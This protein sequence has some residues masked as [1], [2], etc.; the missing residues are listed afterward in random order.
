MLLNRRRFVARMLSFAAPASI[1]LGRSAAGAEPGA[2][3]F[4]PVVTGRALVF[5]DDEGSHPYFRIEWWYLTGWLSDEMNRLS[6]FQITFF[7]S[8][9]QSTGGNP[10]RFAPTQL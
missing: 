2:D 8:R 5:P 1:D 3:A 6:G 7:R 4:P 10:S 9:P